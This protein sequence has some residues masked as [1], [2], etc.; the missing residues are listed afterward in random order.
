MRNCERECVSFRSFP[1][2]PSFAREVPC[3]SSRCPMPSV[4]RKEH[5]RGF[6]HPRAHSHIPEFR[7]GSCSERRSLHPGGLNWRLTGCGPCARVA[8]ARAVF[9]L[10]LRSSQLAVSRR[11]GVHPSI[12][13]RPLPLD[14]YACVPSFPSRQESVRKGRVP[15]P[16]IRPAALA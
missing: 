10:S 13:P 5:H 8:V 3:G 7:L 11:F 2:L 15:L 16:Q 12:H 6:Y 4:N 9:R 1:Q 14:E